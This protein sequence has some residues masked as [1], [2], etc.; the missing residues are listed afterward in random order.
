MPLPEFDSFGDLPAGVHQAT[1]DEVLA[2]FGYADPQRQIVSARLL[3]I[4][5]LA[6][7]TGKLLRFV[8][9]GSYVTAKRAP[10]DVDIILIMRDDFTQQD[11][12]A[13]AQSIFDHQRA[14]Q[15]IGASVFAIRPSQILLETVDSFIAHWQIKRDR[16]RRGIVEVIGER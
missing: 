2:R 3:H 10:N 14:Q 13:E 15:E 1:L 4:Y 11:C 7:G 6:R 9:F 8:I 5:N 12:A 16:S